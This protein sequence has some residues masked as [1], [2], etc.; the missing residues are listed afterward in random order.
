MTAPTPRMSTTRRVT[1]RRYS[2]RAAVVCDILRGADIAPD[3]NV[4]RALQVVTRKYPDLTFA[5]GLM[6]DAPARGN[7]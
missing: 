5:A 7:A 1:A 2:D 3:A 6:A 4:M